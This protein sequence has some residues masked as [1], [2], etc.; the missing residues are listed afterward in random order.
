M[1]VMWDDPTVQCSV[2]AVLDSA[3]QCGSG[4]GQCSA[5]W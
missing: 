3:V 4:I 1:N 2:V 5:V